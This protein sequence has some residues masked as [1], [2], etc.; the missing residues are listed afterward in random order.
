MQGFYDL[1]S[2]ADLLA[3]LHREHARL[4]KD[5]T[6]VDTAWN[7]FVTAEHMLDWHIP[8]LPS[9]KRNSDRKT[10]VNANPILQICSHIANG[11]KHFEALAKRHE[12]VAGTERSGGYFS[13]DYFGAAT[14]P[15]AT[16]EE[17]L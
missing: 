8:D 9:R 15:R 4:K 11:A 13:S 2:P 1:K 17:T 12:S 14:S 3:K 6:D 5:P 7:L 10:V 16:L